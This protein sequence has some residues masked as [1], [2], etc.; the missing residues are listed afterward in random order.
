M[1]L[2][3]H[4]QSGAPSG[5]ESY[6]AGDLWAEDV[7]AVIDGLGLGR[8]VLVGW[9]YGGLVVSDYLRRF[10][11]DGI[12]GV[13]FVGAAVGIGPDWFG[14]RIGRG[15]LDH[16]PNACSEDQTVAL[17]AVRAFL[18]TCFAR[19]VAAADRELAMGWTMLVPPSVRAHLIDREEDFTPDLARLRV[20]VLVSQGAL[21]TVILPAMA[22]TIRDHVPRCEM[23]VYEDAGHAPFLEEPERFN[24]ELAEFVR[25]AAG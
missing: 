8:P 17:Q 20:P 6:T 1:D 4:G 2:R 24:A 21:D 25:S 12:A 14:A 11:D 23:S 15:F 3:G 13:N 5:R 18:G 9:S 19:P 7:R 22:G 16:A 10:G